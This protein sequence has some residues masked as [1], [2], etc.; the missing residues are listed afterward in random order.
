M[1]ADLPPPSVF[2]DIA[3]GKTRLVDGL[4][5]SL[6]IAY[7]V[8]VAWRLS[9]NMADQELWLKK[10]RVQLW[11][12]LSSGLTTIAVPVSWSYYCDLSWAQRYHKLMQSG[13][14]SLPRGDEDLRGRIFNFLVFQKFS[15]TITEFYEKK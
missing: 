6:K 3:E 15:Q 11:L 1:S 5:P 7:D 12:R 14:G 4:K 2:W 9:K 8:A 10:A 13:V